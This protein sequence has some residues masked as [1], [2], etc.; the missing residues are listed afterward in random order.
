MYAIYIYRHHKYF[1][2]IFKT[3]H[4]F[5]LLF[6]WVK[7]LFLYLYV[8]P[9][10]FVFVVEWS[11]MVNGYNSIQSELSDNLCFVCKTFLFIPT[12]YSDGGSIHY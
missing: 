11:G 2:F 9:F 3:I 4:I 10:W 6:F 7:S 5:F 1:N 8:Y 12:G